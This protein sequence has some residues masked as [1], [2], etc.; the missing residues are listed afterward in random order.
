MRL[1][2]LVKCNMRQVTSA[3]YLYEDVLVDTIPEDPAARR[4]YW[5]DRCQHQSEETKLFGVFAGL[6]KYHP[7]HLT[8]EEL[9]QWR[10]DPGGNPYLVAKI[11]EKFEEL[12]EKSRGGY[13]PWFLRHRTR[14]ELPDD[15]RSIPR[16]P[17]P[18]TQIR[19]MQARARKY[20]APEDQHKAVEDL[21]PFAK[22]HCFG[23]YSMVADH[24]HPSP[25]NREHCHWFD[26]GFVVC[27]DQREEQRLGSMYSTMILGSTS[28]EDIVREIGSSNVARWTNKI[29]PT[30]SFDEFW[31][32]WERG[33]LM[34]MFDK[35][36]PYYLPRGDTFGNP[37]HD[38]LNRLR[39]FLEAETP[40]PSIWH[41]RHF[42][43]MED[44]SVESAAPGIARAARDYGFSE[45]LNT[46]TTMELSTFYLQ[47]MKNA[48][49]LAVH[50]ERMKGNL[51]HFAEGRVD[52]ITPRVKKLLQGL[53]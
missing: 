53:S 30:C 5:F 37:E 40:R 38:F 13:F 21:T 23:I 4:D 36:W 32:A 44:A 31:R 27:H 48:E 11:V 50:R 10:S 18:T 41:L 49:P 22:L 12:P 28:Y 46:R 25:V 15:D 19:N 8:R 14:F 24:L 33:T 7:N 47:L 3:D 2:H 1:E 16:S 42:L 29:S 51:V 43:A 6:L 9:H 26:F 34:T 39:A 45:Q 17:S 20:L 35:C 52:V